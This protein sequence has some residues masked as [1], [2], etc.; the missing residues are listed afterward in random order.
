MKEQASLL[1][2]TV[3]EDPNQLVQIIST[4][5]SICYTCPRNPESPSYDQLQKQCA[6]YPNPTTNPLEGLDIHAAEDISDLVDG[7]I[8]SSATLLQRLGQKNQNLIKRLFQEDAEE[9]EIISRQI[10]SLLKK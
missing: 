8:I 1:I 2:K 4:K 10:R 9:R 6:S 7:P 3:L 5:D